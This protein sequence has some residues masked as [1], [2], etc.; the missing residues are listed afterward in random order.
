MKKSCVKVIED[1]DKREEEP[2]I[3]SLGNWRHPL[4]LE[5]KQ[6]E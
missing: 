4:G 1:I 6:G 2:Y 5:L 3:K